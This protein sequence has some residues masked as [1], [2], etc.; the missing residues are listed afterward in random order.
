[1]RLAATIGHDAALAI[2]RELLAHTR[3]LAQSFAGKAVIWY[4]NEMPEFDLWSEAGFDRYQQQGADLGERMAHAFEWGWQQG[5]ERIAIIGSDCATLTSEI[6]ENAFVHLRETDAVIG[7]AED[8]GYYLL[9]MS[10]W[11]P[12]VFQQKNW[13]TET[14]CEATIA[15]LQIA[16]RSFALLPTLSDVDTEADVQGTF[17]EGFLASL[18]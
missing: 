13:S 17:L 5:Y 2:Y 1:T 4:G 14:V 12:A 3:R 18:S 16:N 15:D 8:G 10:Q 11:T 9:G 7:P 6:L